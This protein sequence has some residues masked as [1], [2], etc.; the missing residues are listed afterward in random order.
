MNLLS[1]HQKFRQAYEKALVGNWKG[2][3]ESV[4]KHLERRKARGHLPLNATEADLIQKGM[5]VLNSSDAMVYEYAAF[6]GMYFIVHQEWAVFFDE[7]GLWDT[8]F[9]PDRPERYF[10]LTKGYRPIGKLIEL[11]K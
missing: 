4:S 8:V 3:L 1:R 6:E 10:T 5:G 11:T 9:P 7:S 2:G